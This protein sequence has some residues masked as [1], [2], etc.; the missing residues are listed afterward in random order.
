MKKS[1]YSF[2]ALS[3]L[4]SVAHAQSSVTLYGIIDASVMTQSKTGGTGAGGRVTSFVD[5]PI[6]PSIYGFKGTEDLGGGLSAGFNLEGGFNAGNG[7]HNS[8]GVTQNN[9]FGREAKVTLSGADWGSVGAGLQVDPALIAS[10]STE[11]R[12]LT[13]SFSMLEYWILATVFNGSG[14]NPAGATSLQGGIFDNNSLTYTYAKNGLYLGLEYGFGGVAGS[15]SANSTESIGAS[16]SKAGFIVSGSYAKNNNANPAIGGSSS[17]IGVVGLGYDF[18]AFAVRGQYGAFRSSAGALLGVANA[19][20][21]V[22]SWGVGL[23]WKPSAANKINISYYDAKDTGASFG[24]KTS[25]I[26]LLDIYSLSKRT[27][28]YGQLVDVKADANA[29][30]SAGIGGVYVP[31]GFFSSAGTSTLYFGVGVQHSF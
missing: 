11:P 26:A 20:S 7:T 25:E 17:Q 18:G 5:A 14:L 22:Q 1:L 8:P 30:V 6:L 2:I 24:G 23:D 29:G 16:Y 13:D 9:I 15:T 27:Q 4:A 31:S 3:A 10:I 21:D 19:T 12:G 28:I